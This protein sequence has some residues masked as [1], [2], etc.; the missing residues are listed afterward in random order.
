MDIGRIPE[1]SFDKTEVRV[2][3]P[4]GTWLKSFEVP[5]E[6]YGREWKSIF[7][8]EAQSK[9]RKLKVLVYRYSQRIV[10]PKAAFALCEETLASN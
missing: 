6:V 5:S 4:D 2:L 10:D 9:G 3:L 1:P 7:E 8:A